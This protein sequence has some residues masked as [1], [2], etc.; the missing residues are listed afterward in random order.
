M[1]TGFR[2]RVECLN[3][4]RF[5]SSEYVTVDELVKTAIEVS[6]KKIHKKYVEG[7]V[8]VQARNPSTDLRT[9]LQQDAYPLAGVES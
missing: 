3:D 4:E 6:G 2:A 9:S 7:P 5:G 1:R 8:G